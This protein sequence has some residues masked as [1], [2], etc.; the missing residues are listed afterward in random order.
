MPPVSDLALAGVG[1]ALAGAI[2]AVAGGGTLVSFPILVGLGVPSLRANVTNTISLC[3]GYFSG[4]YAQRSQLGSSRNRVFKATPIA[5]LGGLAGSV[6]LVVTSESLFKAVVPW[7]IICASLLLGFQDR[8]KSLVFGHRGSD[9]RDVPPGLAVGVFL[10]AVYGGYFGAGLGIMVLAVLGLVLDDDIKTLN[11][12]KT[13]LSSAINVVAA[14]FLCF[15]GKAEWAFVLVMAPS[16][17]VGGHIGGIFATKM[18]PRAMRA[19][20]ISFGLAVAMKM[21]LF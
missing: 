12:L 16:S 8:I 10:S 11:A 18:N 2:N 20:V 1:S 19:V 17:L 5:A 3:P 21:L 6:L 9:H 13:W 7:L 14:A 15:S 4:A